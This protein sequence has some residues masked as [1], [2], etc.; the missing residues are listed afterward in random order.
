[1]LYSILPV[2][3]C[4]CETW[5]VTLT[6]E[7]TSRMRLFKSKVLKIFG[8]MREE[9]RGGWGKWHTEELH[10]L[11]SLQNIVRMIKSGGQNRWVMCHTWGRNVSSILVGRPEGKT[12]F[13]R[14]SLKWEDNIKMDI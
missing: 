4:G 10:G 13:G 14:P 9:V 7:H 3:L 11:Y 8:P 2:V 5:S 1:L 12:P 6:E